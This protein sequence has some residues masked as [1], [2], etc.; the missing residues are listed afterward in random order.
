MAALTLFFLFGA[1]KREDE[2]L[3]VAAPYAVFLIAALTVLP[4][5]A[6]CTS[7]RGR[8]FFGQ[9]VSRKA[10]VLEYWVN[11]NNPDAQ[12]ALTFSAC[13]LLLPLMFIPAI[14]FNIRGARAVTAL[15]NPPIK[16][17]DVFLTA[18]LSAAGFV[19]TCVWLFALW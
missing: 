9:S 5:Y 4:M 13:G 12:L 3:F 17:G 19:V 11:G 8:L 6:V 1:D 15:T 10:L 16:R 7:P 14:V 2:V 18:C